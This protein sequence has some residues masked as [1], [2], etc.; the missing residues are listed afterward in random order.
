MHADHD[1]EY[2]RLDNTGEHTCNLT[3][4][5]T[6]FRR[7][8]APSD[9]IRLW[10]RHI[11][12]AVSPEMLTSGKCKTI[13][14]PVQDV[15]LASKTKHSHRYAEAASRVKFNRTISMLA[16]QVVAAIQQRSGDTAGKFSGVHLRIEEDA[17]AWF[18]GDAYNDRPNL[19]RHFK[20]VV[21]N[22]DAGNTVF[23]AGAFNETIEAEI[24]SFFERRVVTKR[25]LLGE[26]QLSGLHSEQLALLDFLVLTKAQYF[27]GFVASS[28]SYFCQEYRMLL[29]KPRLTSYLIDMQRDWYDFKEVLAVGTES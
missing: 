19:L 23:I 13:V 24:G 5:P 29:G 10:K 17:S 16:D 15:F 2:V 25:M 14:E 6:L 22:F 21:Y 27:V 9:V 7:G 18:V 11:A 26:S 1:I 12:D 20:E 3:E 8:L 4:L 28:M